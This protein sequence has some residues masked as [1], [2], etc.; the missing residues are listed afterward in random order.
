MKHKS[1]IISIVIAL[2]LPVLAYAQTSNYW[3]PNVNNLQPIINTYGLQ[4]PKLGSTGSPCVS[5]SSTGVFATTTCGGGGTNFFSNSGATTTLTTGSILIAPNLTYPDGTSLTS[6]TATTT[7]SL[8]KNG[9]LKDANGSTGAPNQIL[10]VGFGGTPAW[11]AVTSFVT[12]PIANVFGYIGC[13]TCLTTASQVFSTTTINGLA[14]TTFN[15]STTSTGTVFTISTSSSGVNFNVPPSTNY[16]SNSGASTSLTTGSNLLVG[17]ITAGNFIATSTTAT[18]TFAAPIEIGSGNLF[19]QTLLGTI[20]SSSSFIQ[21]YITNT[22]ASSGASADFIV[23]NNLST[24][25][26]YYGDFGINSSNWSGNGES[27]NDT[28][29]YSSDGNL[30]LEAGTTS[31]STGSISFFTGGINSTS[32]IR[33]A[34]LSNGSIGIGS[35]SP[36]S[37]NAL[38]VIGTISTSS[39]AIDAITNSSSNGYAIQGHGGTATSSYGGYFDDND[40]SSSGYAVF[41]SSTVGYAFGVSGITNISSPST[42]VIGSSGGNCKFYEPFT[43]VSLKIV[44]F[45]CTSFSGTA[46]YNFPVAFSQIPDSSGVGPSIIVSTISATSVTLQ[47]GLNAN[48]TGAIMGF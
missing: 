29:L 47:P 37:L 21:D 15:F 27:P 39:I 41:A 5:V 1:K 13:P 8:Y 2:F 23:N 11:Q 10:V 28:F 40:K 22:S 42:T 9:Y 46:T 33:M 7:L 30:D 44:T 3:Y 31:T 20:A 4:I 19:P 36:Q 45:T 43:G 24:N 6:S 14:T 35:T 26:T 12:S 38:T 17:L 16:F 32:T 25:S 18:S 48:G 34:I